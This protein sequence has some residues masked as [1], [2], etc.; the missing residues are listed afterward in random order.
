MN[1]LA[2]AAYLSLF[3]ADS[4]TTRAAFAMRSDRVQVRELFLAQN[5]NV[6]DAILAGQATALLWATSKIK[7]PALRWTIRFGVAGI[8]GYAA[9]HNIQ[10]IRKVQR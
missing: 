7:Q 1:E 9:V 2:L 6:N 8:H 5:P 4:A 3:A 10:Q